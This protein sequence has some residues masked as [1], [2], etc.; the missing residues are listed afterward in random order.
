MQMR[1]L[2]TRIMPQAQNV[3]NRPNPSAS[4]AV[5]GLYCPRRKNTYSIPQHWQFPKRSKNW[6]MLEVACGCMGQY[7][8]QQGHSETRLNQRERTAQHL[9][10][11]ARSRPCSKQRH[12]ARFKPKNTPR[13]LIPIPSVCPYGVLDRTAQPA[14]IVLMPSLR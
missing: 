5:R 6:G 9:G 4:A 11:L 10:V 13:S 1:R 2:R 7:P 3:E 8:K 12:T 14:N